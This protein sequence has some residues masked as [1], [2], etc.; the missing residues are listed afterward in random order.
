MAN[1]LPMSLFELMKHYDLFIKSCIFHM[2]NRKQSEEIIGMHSY[3]GIFRHPSIADKYPDRKLIAISYYKDTEC[4]HSIFNITHD[5][6]D[7]IVNFFDENG[8]IINLHRITLLTFIDSLPYYIL[9]RCS[10]SNYDWIIGDQLKSRKGYI[11]DY[12]LTLCKINIYDRH[13]HDVS[14]I[15]KSEEVFRKIT[16]DHFA[17]F[18]EEQTKYGNFICILS[19]GLYD[20][21]DASL[22]TICKVKIPIITYEQRHISSTNIKADYLKNICA[23]YGA[24]KE[25]YMTNANMEFYDDDMLNIYLVST[26]GIKTVLVRSDSDLNVLNTRIE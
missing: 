20:V 14:I 22:K 19:L 6:S 10:D 13:Q 5:G 16:L 12:D 26:L 7:Y 25:K 1:P 17:K 23:Y 21:I 4:E 8:R 18:V 15:T 2:F 3:A 9:Y 11:F 24:S